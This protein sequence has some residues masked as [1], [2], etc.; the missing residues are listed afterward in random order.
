MSRRRLSF[1]QITRAKSTE[2]NT[3]PDPLELLIKLN[4]F[5]Q[6]S[7]W[8]RPLGLFT[9][10]ATAASIPVVHGEPIQVLTTQT[11]LKNLASTAGLIWIDGRELSLADFALRYSTQACVVLDFRISTNDES[12]L[13]FNRY[14]SD[15]RVM[16]AVTPQQA[17]WVVGDCSASRVIVLPLLSERVSWDPHLQWRDKAFLNPSK[18]SASNRTRIILDCESRALGINTIPSDNAQYLDSQYQAQ[19]IKIVINEAKSRLAAQS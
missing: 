4:T 2:G 9:D 15:E 11:E 19:T 5:K 16:I 13:A 8:F 17:P 7:S 18:L 12:K 14:H 1:I 3:K 10:D 6:L